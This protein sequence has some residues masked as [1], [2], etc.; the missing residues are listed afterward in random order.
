MAKAA[1]LGHV[2]SLARDLRWGE[3]EEFGRRKDP[4]SEKACKVP[5]LWN[6]GTR[7]VV[8]LHGH[9]SSRWSKSDL[10]LATSRVSSKQ[11]ECAKKRKQDIS[12]N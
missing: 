1:K 9:R 12:V 4:A 3:F 6:R 11:I 8:Y 2:Q 5:M 10:I 7:D